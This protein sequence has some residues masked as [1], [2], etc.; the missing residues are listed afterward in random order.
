[1]KNFK[2]TCR[3]Q[4]GQAGFSLL[5]VLIGIAIFA[6]GMLALASLQGALTRSSAEAKVRT[7][8]VN[9]AEQIIEG[10]K[11]FNLIDDFTGIVDQTIYFDSEMSDSALKNI[12]LKLRKKLDTNIISTI[13]GHGFILE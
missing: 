2:N 5:E 1:M 10:H 11:G 4:F 6:I 7:T 8:A 3:Y 9:I 13:S 12:L